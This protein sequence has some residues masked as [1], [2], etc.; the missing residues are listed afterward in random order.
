MS[1]GIFKFAQKTTFLQDWAVTFFSLLHPSIMHNISKIEMIKKA[2][3][4]C[5]LEYVEGAYFEFGVYEGTSLL[6]AVKIHN[7][8]QS[9]FQRNFYGFDSFD[10][11]LK[12]FDDKD[13]HPFFEEGCFRS[14]YQKVT[15]RF[16]RFKNVRLIKGYFE[17]TVQNKQIGQISGDQR[18]AV[19]FI[20][21]DLMNP[22]LIALRFVRPILQKGCVIIL[23]DFYA[24]KGNPSLGTA[25]ALNKFLEENPNIKVREY[26]RYGYGGNSFIVIEV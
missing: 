19:V 4:H 13:R 16:K 10:Q 2:L 18:C 24:Y 17:E 14:S 1:K 3:W 9:R 21:C 8:L 11:G 23:D 12:Y 22:A 7:K 5:E 20:D 26:H 25:G 15:R 6:A